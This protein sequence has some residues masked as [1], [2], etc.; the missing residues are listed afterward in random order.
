M[1]EWLW[2]FFCGCAWLFAIGVGMLV[3]HRLC[4]LNDRAPGPRRKL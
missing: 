1:N 3:F 4:D 2:I